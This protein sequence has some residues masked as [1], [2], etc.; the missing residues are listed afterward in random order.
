M[1]DAVPTR[2]GGSLGTNTNNPLMDKGTSARRQNTSRVPE[3][4]KADFMH[5]GDMFSEVLYY[6]VTAMGAK[7]IRK[8]AEYTM[9]DKQGRQLLE[10]WLSGTAPDEVTLDDDDW[11]DYMRKEPNLKEQIHKKL[12]MDAYQ[13]RERLKASAG[14]LDEDFEVSFHGE[15]GEKAGFIK[16][17]GYFTG[18]QILHGSKKTDTLK[19]VQIIGKRTTVWR[20]TPG[21]AYAVTYH[22]LQFIWNDII[23]VNP[24]YKMDRILANY[25]RWEEEYTGGAKPKDYSIHIK[26]K[27]T[28]PVT[29][30]ITTILPVFREK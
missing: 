16:Y 12:E 29:I 5:P 15:V 10:L 4:T 3:G 20:G 30:E 18:Y 28:E 8:A 23:N 19:D 26:W 13:V 24:Q 22:D 1:S 6:P 17:G 21:G 2:G 14:R 11:G 27:G 25:S 9:G 7:A